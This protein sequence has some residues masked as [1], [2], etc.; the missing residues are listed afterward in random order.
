[1]SKSTCDLLQAQYENKI[2]LDISGSGNWAELQQVIENGITNIIN[3][4]VTVSFW[5]KTSTASTIAVKLRQTGS[6]VA[7]IGSQNK[8]IPA[9]K[10]TFV[11]KTFYFNDASFTPTQPHLLLAIAMFT[12]ATYEIANVKLEVNKKHS[13]YK[14]PVYA[15]EIASCQRYYQKLTLKY[16]GD[17]AQGDSY[18]NGALMPK[19]AFSKMR[20]APSVSVGTSSEQLGAVL[21]NQASQGVGWLFSNGVL[22]ATNVNDSSLTPRIKSAT[23]TFTNS[24]YKILMNGTRTIA[25]SADF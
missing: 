1:M 23:Y 6:A 17:F 18:Q 21:A 10:W 13:D 12:S 20:T 25:L 9:S 7:E 24:G 19:L 2:V 5:I 16:Y 4:P 15:D 11:E 3:M 22:D 14:A 8:S